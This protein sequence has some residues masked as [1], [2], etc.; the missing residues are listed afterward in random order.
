M[1][2]LLFEMAGADGARV[3]VEQGAFQRVQRLALVELAEILRRYAGSDRCPD[4]DR[5][6][7]CPYSFSAAAVNL[8]GDTEVTSNDP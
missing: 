2:G 7:E 1:F 3:G 6:A 4:V 5:S 8:T